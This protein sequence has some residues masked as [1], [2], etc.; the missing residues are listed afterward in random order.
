MGAI[1]S[2][3]EKRPQGWRN[4][5]PTWDLNV[6]RPSTGLGLSRSLRIYGTADLVPRRAVHEPITA[7]EA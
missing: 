1:V 4:P 3:D 6:H 2:F 7:R 5:P